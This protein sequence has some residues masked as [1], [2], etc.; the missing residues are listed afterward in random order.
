MHPI[1][2]VC[3]LIY[4][5]RQLSHHPTLYFCSSTNQSFTFSTAHFKKENV[6]LLITIGITTCQHE[7]QKMYPQGTHRTSPN[8][9]A[10]LKRAHLS[11]SYMQNVGKLYQDHR[12]LSCQMQV[13]LA[14]DETEP[15]ILYLNVCVTPSPP[16]SPLN[17]PSHSFSKR[18][19][20]IQLWN[21]TNT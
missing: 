9:A 6:L 8:S 19:K 16:P 20:Q 13:G 3:C 12:D 15:V 14:G 7:K 4:T 21:R 1:T 5:R 18:A 11:H 2:S 10:S 17:F